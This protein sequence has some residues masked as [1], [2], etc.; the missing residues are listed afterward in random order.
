MARAIP[1]DH[2]IEKITPLL[3]PQEAQNIS[4]KGTH[5]KHGATVCKNRSTNPH[6]MSDTDVGL[7]RVL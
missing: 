2:T 4:S 5:P 1:E 7:I 3:T 6:L